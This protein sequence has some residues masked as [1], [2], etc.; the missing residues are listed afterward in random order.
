MASPMQAPWEIVRLF[1]GRCGFDVVER[2]ENCHQFETLVGIIQA[3]RDHERDKWAAALTKAQ[4]EREAYMLEANALRL[5]LVENNERHVRAAEA[6]SAAV[7]RGQAARIEAGRERDEAKAETSPTGGAEQRGRAD[8]E[9]TEADILDLLRRLASGEGGRRTG[10]LMR[11]GWIRVA[12]T[13]AG[14]AVLSM[15]EC[16]GCGSHGGH[17]AWCP[18][19]RK[20]AGRV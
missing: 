4:E 15:V 7:S 3:D 19:A 17:F 11:R 8:A 2:P 13:E 1:F 20:E 5:S 14:R 10:D 18:V 9:A 12:V 6:L 16:D